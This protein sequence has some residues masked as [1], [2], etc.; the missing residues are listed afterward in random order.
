[1]VTLGLSDYTPTEKALPPGAMVNAAGTDMLRAVA[2]SN[3]DRASGVPPDPGPLP[4]KSDSEYWPIRYQFPYGINQT[5]T[6]RAGTLTKFETLR[7]FADLS[8]LVRIAI[9]A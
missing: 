6:P 9:E 3:A 2:S 7:S 4:P 8:D 5:Y 1:M